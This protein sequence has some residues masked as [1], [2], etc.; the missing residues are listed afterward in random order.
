MKLSVL[1]RTRYEYTSAVSASYN[2][3]H[4][5]PTSSDGQE[6]HSFLLRVL[7]ATRLS[8]YNDFYNNVVHFFEVPDPHDSLS[9]EANS[10]VT[11]IDTRV[12]GDATVATLDR[13]PS[14]IEMD[15]CY[16]F[17]QMS[18][19]VSVEPDVWRLAMDATV[20]QTDVWQTSLSIMR[21]IHAHFAYVPLSTDVKTHMSEVIQQR[22]GVCQDFAH[23]MLGMCRT[24]KIPARYVSGYLYNGPT[25]HLIGAQASHAW[26]EVFLPGIGWR[27]L[28]PT[29]NQQP[30]E[31][32]VKI[33]VGRDYADIVPLKGHYRGTP[34]RAMRVDVSV[35][36]A[37]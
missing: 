8:H 1:H 35:A 34:V 22:R 25:E 12:A 21:F 6:C 13:L 17:L 23:V 28:D 36:L 7:P 11:T 20:G 29:N 27:G 15:R 18:P 32:Y 19:Y 5:Q 16:D 3:A 2:E 10:I 30:N 33:G 4:L 31:H 37:Q 26:C 9:V 14:L 24:L